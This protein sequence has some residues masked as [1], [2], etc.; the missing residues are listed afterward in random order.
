[1]KGYS[2]KYFIIALCLSVP[3]VLRLYYNNVEVDELTL[4][5]NSLFFA[6]TIYIL[7]HFLFATTD[8]TIDVIYASISV[9][10]LIGVFF[11]IVFTLLEYLMAGSFNVP[12]QAGDQSFYTAFAEDLIYFSFITL[13]TTG[14]GDIVPLLQPARYLAILEAITGQIY[15][16]VIIA[17]LIGMHISQVKN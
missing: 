1:M 4:I 10:F 14:Y 12:Q 9:Y 17:R 13:T 6:F 8:V 5:L 2:K 15:L 7:L 11:G 16:T 3:T